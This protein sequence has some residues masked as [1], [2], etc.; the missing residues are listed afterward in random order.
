MF[1]FKQYILNIDSISK[2]S[3]SLCVIFSLF[4]PP[5]NVHISLHHGGILPKQFN[6][7]ENCVWSEI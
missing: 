7:G 5:Q 2:H 4:F 6:E 1:N 3:I